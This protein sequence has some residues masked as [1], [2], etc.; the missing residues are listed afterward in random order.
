MSEKE[1]TG[2]RKPLVISPAAAVV[3][4]ALI[5]AIVANMWLDAGSKDYDGLKA[6]A[7]LAVLFAGVLGF[8]LK[9]PGRGDK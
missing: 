6:T 5:A 3:A 8:D 9:F 4:L 2:G 1:P 7:I